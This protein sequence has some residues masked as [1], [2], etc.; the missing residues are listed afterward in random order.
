MSKSKRNIIIACAAAAV[1]VIG[2]VILLAIDTTPKNADSESSDETIYTIISEE[3]NN[4]SDIVVTS[5]NGEIKVTNL[6]DTV[7]TVNDMSTDDIDTSK[8]YSLAGTVS[9]LTSKTK[10]PVTDDTD[11]SEYGLDEPQVTVKITDKNGK[12]ETVYVGDCSPTLGEYFVIKDGD[13]NIYTIYSYKVDTMKY[14]LEYYREFNR[15]SINIDDIYSIKIIRSDETIILKLTDVI[16][17]NTNNVWEMVSP[18]ESGANDDYIDNKILEPIEG[19]T[20][21]TLAENDD[22]GISSTSPVLVLTVVPYDKTT[23]QTGESYTETLKIGRTD[24]NGTYVKYKDNVFVVPS[25]ELSF[26]NESSFNIV[27]KLQALVDISKVSAVTLDYDGKQHTMD[28]EHKDSEFKFKVDGN[29]VD[30]SKAQKMYQNIIALNVDAIY[31]GEELGDTVMTITY[32]GIK[33]EG[34]TV[35]EFK[36]IDALN[37][38]LVRDGKADFTI[39]KSKLTEFMKTFD[40]YAENPNG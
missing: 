33:N 20:L 18:Y 27:S 40:E 26:I 28:I 32:Q 3:A 35:V 12:T 8:A 6:G 30:S 31:K 4:I 2:I 5:E 23:G 9:T 17:D 24:E 38:A 14:Q 36:S 1:L 34:D 16:D 21:D 22:G 25:D 29:D 11:L 39:K 37:C 15:F 10:I 7:W 13:P 19:I